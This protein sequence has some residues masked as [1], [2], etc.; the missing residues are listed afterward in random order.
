LISNRLRA[1]PQR[2]H[3]SESRRVGEYHGSRAT[4]VFLRSLIRDPLFDSGFLLKATREENTAGAYCD[5]VLY[6]GPA[7]TLTKAYEETNR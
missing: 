1:W 3:A 2:G 6:L 5:A 4:H 7:T